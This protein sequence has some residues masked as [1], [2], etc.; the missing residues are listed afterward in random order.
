[1]FKRYYRWAL[2]EHRVDADPTL[3]LLAAH[4]RCACRAPE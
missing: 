4:S 1:V 2:R 3:R